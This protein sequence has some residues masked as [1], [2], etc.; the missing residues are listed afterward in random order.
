MN[1][2]TL[3]N[4]SARLILKSD[5]KRIADTEGDTTGSPVGTT[6]KC[7][8][9]KRDLNYLFMV[10]LITS[11]DNVVGITNRLENGQSSICG[12]IRGRSNRYSSSTN[13][14]HWIWDPLSLVL[15]GYWLVFL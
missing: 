3:M 14:P 11:L 8:W 10:Y 15:D 4:C 2:S 13:H 7:T 5:V 12:L 6:R 9:Y 1:R